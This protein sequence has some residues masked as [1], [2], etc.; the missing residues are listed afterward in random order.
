M[1]QKER[2]KGEK[3]TVDRVRERRIDDVEH[4]K[5]DERRRIEQEDIKR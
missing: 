5:Q 2:K 1:K 3:D 4:K